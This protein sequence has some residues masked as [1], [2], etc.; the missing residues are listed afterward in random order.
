MIER[1]LIVDLFASQRRGVIKVFGIGFGV[2]FEVVQILLLTQ[3]PYVV[4][5]IV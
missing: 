5:S 2:T 1:K 4:Y 3:Y